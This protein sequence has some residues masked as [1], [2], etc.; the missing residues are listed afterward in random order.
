MRKYLLV[1]TALLTACA[2]P[3]KENPGTKPAYFD[4]KGYFNKEATT[5]KAKQPLV[6]KRVLVDDKAEEKQVKVSDWQKELSVFIDADINKAAWAGEFSSKNTPSGITYTSNSDK[7]PVKA[8][9]VLKANGVV[10]GIII[11]IHNSNYLY[12]S[13]DT[14]SYYPDSL[15][16]IRKRQEIKLMS[17]KR[18]EITGRF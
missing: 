12:S 13:S 14:L 8:L 10:K 1:F 18:Y 5:L 15:Y 9:Q 2:A 6:S 16:K 4:L 7:V 11:T 3:E 17:P